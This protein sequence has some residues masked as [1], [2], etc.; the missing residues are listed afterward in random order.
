MTL[1]ASV[2]PPAPAA[3]TPPQPRGGAPREAFS[4][5]LDDLMTADAKPQSASKSRTRPAELAAD[6]GAERPPSDP[7]AALTTAALVS[8]SLAAGEA[9]DGGAES[10]PEA[11]GAATLP[12]SSPASSTR[13]AAGPAGADEASPSPRAVAGVKLTAER[14]Y[15]APAAFARA[16]DAAAGSAAPAQPPPD[17]SAAEAALRPPASAPDPAPS[18][19]GGETATL[20]AARGGETGALPA[21]GALT[22]VALSR[23]SEAASIEAKNA[24]TPAS[25]APAQRSKPPPLKKDA[26]SSPAAEVRSAKSAAAPVA[27]SA[28]Q[29]ARRESA[30]DAGAG[31]E[32]APG[33]PGES[34]GQVG[35]AFGLAAPPDPSSVDAAPQS[36]A[37]TPTGATATP[38]EPAPI[39]ARVR[40]IDLDL[41]PSGFKDS[42][43]TVRLAGDKLGVVIRAASGETAATIDSARDAIA[44]RL[45]AIGQ[46]VASL[47]IQQTGANDAKGAL[48]QPAG[49]GEGGGESPNGGASGFGGARRG[50]HRF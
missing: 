21:A 9:R 39:A 36:G 11:G 46:P 17:A 1:V 29:S 37:T 2:A 25:A 34:A 43:M 30:Q 38:A 35:A 22:A 5:A 45:A 44:V 19:G 16:V 20:P 28:S 48:G 3:Q 47:I 27:A 15:L 13:A 7:R 40:E 10:E 23:A 41:G 33:A 32:P 18:A 12:P 26:Q 14:S 31:L 6:A 49:E 4:A 8:L 24:R 42:T 50:A